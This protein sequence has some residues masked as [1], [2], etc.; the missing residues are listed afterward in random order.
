[1]CKSL[2][3][4]IAGSNCPGRRPFDHINRDFS[5]LRA[6][7]FEIRSPKEHSEK[8]ANSLAVE[9]VFVVHGMHV[10]GHTQ[11]SAFKIKKIQFMKPFRFNPF[12]AAATLVISFSASAL[13]AS[14][15]WDVNSSDPGLGGTGTW[16]ATNA[17]WD[18]T[19]SG[20][21][22][23]TETTIAPT[24]T[25]AD[26]A[27]FGGTA[28]NVTVDAVTVGGLNFTSSGYNLSGGTITLGA[29][30]TILQTTSSTNTTT[31]SSKISGTSKLILNATSYSFYA[32]LTLS[33][34]NDYSGGT[35]LNHNT[36]VTIGNATA[37]GTGT[38][39]VNG[40]FGQ[41]R[42]TSALTIANNIVLNNNWGLFGSNNVTTNGTLNLG[43][44]TRTIEVASGRTFVIGGNT[45]NGAL[46]KT[47][48]G[49][50]RL[51]N[52]S[53]TG[54]TTVS[55]GTLRIRNS[56]SSS[57][58]SIASGAN[59]QLT[60]LTL[61]S[62]QNIT[63]AGNVST[64]ASVFG[65]A[66]LNGNNNNYTGA[67]TV[68]IDR[69]RLGTG[70]VINGTNGITVEGQWSANFE[71][72]GSTTTTGAV[73]VNGYAG[74]GSDTE[75]GR[76]FNGN[77]AG[78]T[79]GSLSA[80][81]ISLG[82]SFRS[83]A[84]SK[85]KGGEFFNYANST[86]NLGSGAITV[87]GQGNSLAGGMTA[88]G[89]TFTN[90]GSVTAGS[91]TLNSS[92][93]ANTSSN[94]GGTYTQSGGSTTLSGTATLAVNGGT[95]AAGT[96]GNDAAFN[97]SGG[98]FSANSIA[99][100]SGT[101]TATGG[102]LTL[103]TGGITK[104]GTAPTLVNLGATTLAASAAWTSSVNMTL[105]DASTGTTVN[106][107]GGNIGL[108]GELSGSGNLVKSGTGTLT[109]SGNNNY[110]GTTTVSAGTLVL[111]HNAAAGTS[112]GGVT[113]TGALAA[114]LQIN[115]GTTIA[116]DI[117]FSNTNA[118]SSIQR[119]IAASGAYTTGTSGNLT[120]SFTGGTPDTTAEILGGTSAAGGIFSMSFSGTSTALNDGIRRSD[121]FTAAGTSTDTYVVQLFTTP[122]ALGSDSVLGWLNGSNQW[123]NAGST[124]FNETYDFAPRSVGDYGYSGGNVWAVV[125]YGGSFSAIPEPTSA[126][127]ALL[128]GVG[129]LR[130][131]RN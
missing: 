67:T 37:F 38:V 88:A 34:A 45:S 53:Y 93:T 98:T 116:D 76:F 110:T 24:F 30:T 64:D 17:F 48:V 46:T 54:A 7:F 89:S 108:S 2:P 80:A 103:G 120:S 35:D 121:I 112:A 42:A 91:I 75:S 83:D 26:T 128:L 114:T 69:F 123:V 82:S 86:V 4:Y 99:V 6:S 95:G 8:L 97:L 9:G 102:S 71:N 50:L 122:G 119:N 16:N 79:P 101:L 129:L 43:N 78:T 62:T 14:Y 111:D 109:L 11:I 55:N 130:R 19:A 31:I 47:G 131:R 39:T 87:N 73:N 27:I 96:A 12:V 106:T 92:S 44:A 18:N 40:F 49:I 20:A 65:S 5:L 36:I 105:T 100:N 15:Q 33:G 58:F 23:G 25:G 51:T 10:A 94:K 61:S 127:A 85:A 56:S 107:T 21:N 52:S 66:T 57:G 84:A 70:G 124:F 3:Q 81:S 117:T 72:F 118:A 32:N 115:A 60:N 22:D 125:D 74:F 29:N 1:M 104:T 41:L 77:A 59:L 68:A 28:G 13:A 63:G 113:L 126:L 90:A